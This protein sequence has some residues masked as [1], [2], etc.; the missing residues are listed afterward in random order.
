[1]LPDKAFDKGVFVGHVA[2]VDVTPCPL[3]YV[4]HLRRLCGVCAGGLAAWPRLV[5]DQAQ[6]RCEGGTVDGSFERPVVGAVVEVN[7]SCLRPG[8]DL[9][10]VI[11]RGI[12]LIFLLMELEGCVSALIKRHVGM[13]LV[14]EVPFVI[15]SPSVIAPDMQND[16]GASE[17]VDGIILYVC[18]IPLRWVHQLILG[19]WLPVIS[20]DA[21]GDLLASSGLLRRPLGLVSFGGEFFDHP[22]VEGFGHCRLVF[23]FAV[24]C[25]FLGSGLVQL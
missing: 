16:F 9:V 6:E 7:S 11:P 3:C 4:V 2:A 24:P 22:I 25:E 17:L 5:A 10:L 8:L 1:M 13:K 19:G 21:V 15:C 18:S 12:C 20:S 14:C 23:R